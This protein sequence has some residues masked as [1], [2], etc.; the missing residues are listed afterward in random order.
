M[1]QS[2]RIIALLLILLWI[3]ASNKEFYVHYSILQIKKCQ[4]QLLQSY[5]DRHL[6]KKITVHAQDPSLLLEG[7]D[8][9]YYKD[10]LYDIVSQRKCPNGF[11]EYILLSDSEEQGLI[12]LLFDAKSLKGTE[13][14]A[15]DFQ[16]KFIACIFSC[17]YSIKDTGSSYW[18][19]FNNNVSENLLYSFIKSLIQ[20]PD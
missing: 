7:E 10:K 1:K 16:Y 9:L 18:S 13:G 17:E 8:E 6:T 5:H 12:N 14:P 19:L 11:I 2:N 4:K 15:I 3:L 20:P